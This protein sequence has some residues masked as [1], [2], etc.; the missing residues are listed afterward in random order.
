M[1]PLALSYQPHLIFGLPFTWVSPCCTATLLKAPSCVW[2]RVHAFLASEL[3]CLAGLENGGDFYFSKSLE[4]GSCKQPCQRWAS[5]VRVPPKNVTQR[6]SQKSSTSRV[7]HL[8]HA[9]YIPSYLYVEMHMHTGIHMYICIYLYIHAYVNIYAHI[10]CIHV[11]ICIHIYVFV[12]IV[13]CCVYLYIY[14]HIHVFCTGH[15]CIS[16]STLTSEASLPWDGPRPQIFFDLAQISSRGCSKFKR[17]C[18]VFWVAVKELKTSYY[19]SAMLF[20][21]IYPKYGNLN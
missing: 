3:E 5:A 13:C 19:N 21:T 18:R 17:R 1:L 11:Y 12:S 4:L 16:C 14:T 10:P 15:T 2:V 7:V 6:A 20:M 9:V 8:V